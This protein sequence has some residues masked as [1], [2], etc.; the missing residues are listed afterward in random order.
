M[1]VLFATFGARNHVH[2][3]VALAWAL[4][5]AGHEVCM[6]SHP[7][8]GDVI[9]RTGLTAVPVGRE[10]NEDQV[11]EELREREDAA[12]DTYD[13]EAPDAQ[14]LLTMDELRP[15]KL[16]YDHMHGVFTA[17]TSAVF[18]N[19]SSTEMIDDL[20]DFARGWRPDLVVWDPLTFAGAVAARVTGAAHARLM[21]GL[22]LVGRMRESYLAEVRGRPA[23]LRED[24]MREWL[25]WVMERYGGA[26]T[27]DL[28]TGQWT[29]DPVPTSLRLPV[30]L[31]YVPVR[32]VAYNGRG[33]IPPW[34]RE[35]PERPRVCL[36]LG[37]SHREV[38]GGD[39]ASIGELIDAV[40]GL[41][42]E[43]VATLNARQL[44]A[45]TSL[46]GNVRTVDFVPMD[47]L[48]PSC[49]AV[50]SH[51]GSGT[52]HTAF[53]Y[54]VPQILVPGTMWDN[55]IRADLVERSGTGLRLDAETLTAAALRDALARV[56]TEPSFVAG[57]DRLRRETLATPSP[58][59][60]V[61]VLESLTAE[62]RRPG[63]TRHNAPA[64]NDV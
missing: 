27:E 32:C 36:T 7:D 64:R 11:M 52:V 50:I 13:E 46:P 19:Y 22:D 1:R 44:R 58:R 25:G 12:R 34:L 37:V 10:L 24:P 59:D 51:G 14:L 57:A 35:V 48:L 40:A 31:P 26:F 23:A 41:D 30:G 18:Q 56:L 2:A 45:V 3:Q 47:A 49:S 55:G 17:M 63:A 39:Q 4:R 54:G 6:A 33:S 16:T 60:I 28:V 8:L 53:L 61:P 5:V 29:I 9:A 15:E 42:V 21:F 20:V 62:H 38:M 43:V